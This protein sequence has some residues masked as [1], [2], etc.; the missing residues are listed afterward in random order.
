MTHY[1]VQIIGMGGESTRPFLGQT[2]LFP[3]QTHR[4]DPCYREKIWNFFR[5]NNRNPITLEVSGAIS[6]ILRQIGDKNFFCPKNGRVLSPPIPMTLMNPL[7][8]DPV[9]SS[10]AGGAFPGGLGGISGNYRHT[11]KSSA[12]G[13]E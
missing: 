5:K 2:C 10:C 13:F 8:R 12:D 3:N 6:Q 11:L 9:V 4:G 7:R 1:I